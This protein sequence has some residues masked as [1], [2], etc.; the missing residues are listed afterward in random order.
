MI[1]HACRAGG[2]VRCGPPWLVGD[3]CASHGGGGQHRAGNTT[4]G[5]F[6]GQ[7][8][9]ITHQDV[10]AAIAAHGTREDT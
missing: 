5:R 6:I 7:R 8:Q 4:I 9:L 2:S 3:A 1:V 10:A